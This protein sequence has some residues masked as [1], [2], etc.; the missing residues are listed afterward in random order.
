MFGKKN[1]MM[2][3]TEI[4]CHSEK[5]NRLSHPS[6]STTL[7]LYYNIVSMVIAL[8][9]GHFLHLNSSYA[10]RGME[11]CQSLLGLDDFQSKIMCMSQW[12]I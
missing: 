8:L 2:G 10:V 11:D 1:Y 12:H 9:L 4:M 3:H 7:S 5:I 6:L